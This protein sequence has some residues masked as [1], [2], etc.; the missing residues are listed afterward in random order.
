[1]FSNKII[2]K[3]DSGYVAEELLSGKLSDSDRRCIVA[4]K[5]IEDKDFTLDEALQV[6][7]VS[8]QDFEDFFIRNFISRLDSSISN[9]SSKKITA[10]LTIHLLSR[11]YKKYLGMID[12][13]AK[14]M[15]DHFN[16]LS[17]Q[18]ETGEYSFT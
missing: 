12:K 4:M 10:L 5:T 2:S 16:T 3:G 13:D 6:Y 11:T 14:M 9:F 17:K 18:I 1:M 15:E 7:E 8:L